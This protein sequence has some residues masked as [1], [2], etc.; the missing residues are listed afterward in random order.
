VIAARAALE[1]GAALNLAGGYHHAKPA[2][3]EG[4][5]LYS[6]IAI[7]VRQM[8]TEGRLASEALVTHIDLDAHMGNGVCH[9]FLDDR[10]SRL[11]DIYN[12]DI[13]P[14]L[15]S[16]ARQRIDC[17]LPVPCGC[18]GKEYLALLRKNLPQFLDDAQRDGLVGLAVYVAGTDTLR[19]DPVGFMTLEPEDVRARDGLVLGE[20]SQRHIPILILPGGGY[21]SRASELIAE[22]AC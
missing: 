19:H 15:D 8:R 7:A 6:D 14:R 22:I 13:Y 9:E 10:R 1:T 17:D 18:G 20:L 16:T 21:T 4:F 2:H 12:R 3:G 5:C 11:F